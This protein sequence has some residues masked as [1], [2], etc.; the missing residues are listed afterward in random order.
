MLRRWGWDHSPAMSLENTHTTQQVVD[1][2]LNLITSRLPMFIRISWT[3]R[4]VVSL[5][6]CEWGNWMSISKERFKGILVA[7]PNVSCSWYHKFQLYTVTSYL[8]KSTSVHWEGWKIQLKNIALIRKFWSV[9]IR[10]PDKL[11]EVTEM[12][13]NEWQSLSVK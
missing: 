8:A 3:Y 13:R 7:H 6:M 5:A 4:N 1:E 9:Q 2:G 12:K 11:S 10:N